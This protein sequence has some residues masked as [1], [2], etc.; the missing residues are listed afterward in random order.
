MST[1]TGASGRNPE[2]PDIHIHNNNFDAGAHVW[3][4]LAT[5]LAIG[6]LVS[7]AWGLAQFGMLELAATGT[8]AV[9]SMLIQLMMRN[10]FIVL[11]HR[12]SDD[13]RI[14][15]G[16]SALKAI[17]GMVQAWIDRSSLLRLVLI[18]TGYGIV[19]VLLRTL[20]QFALG[21][22]GNIWVALA[23]GG[24]VASVICFPTLFAGIIR[25]MKTK[26]GTK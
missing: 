2:I 15:E 5:F 22:F 24:L 3:R 4:V 21:M 13:A 8:A 17:A 23:A 25:S 19:F 11:P 6:A 18:A 7:L 10:G 20:I 14:E 12:Q 1:A 9:L 16:K 26:K